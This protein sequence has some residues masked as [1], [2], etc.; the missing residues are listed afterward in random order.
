MLNN[1]EYLIY[2]D[3]LLLLIFGFTASQQLF[4]SRFNFYGIISLVSVSLYFTLHSIHSNFNMFALLMFLVAIVFIILEVF[5]PGGILGIVGVLALGY[6]MHSIN[7]SNQFILLAIVAAIILFT[8]VSLLNIYVFKKKMLFLNKLVLKDKLSAEKGYVANKSETNLLGKE[9]IA[10]TDLRPS[11]VAI[12]E[13]RKYD[14][15]SQ[16]DFIEKNTKLVVTEVIGM[17]IVV[18]K[19]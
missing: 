19:K 16:G 17:R 14:V 4:S 5:V 11:G 18:S 8:L 15:V 2:V 3:Y 7:D 9:L 12:L 1:P 6:A 13:G 10:Y